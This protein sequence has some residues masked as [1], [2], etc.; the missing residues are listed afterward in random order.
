MENPSRIPTIA[1]LEQFTRASATEFN[2]LLTRVRLRERPVAGFRAW[3]LGAFDALKRGMADQ[4]ETYALWS[5]RWAPW[6]L[7]A[8]VATSVLTIAVTLNDIL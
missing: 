7:L 1:G 8:V 5:P 3:T 2:L 4:D 6:A